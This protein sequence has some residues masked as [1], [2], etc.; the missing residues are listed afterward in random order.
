MKI[1]RKSGKSRK[2]R[3]PDEFPEKKFIISFLRRKPSILWRNMVKTAY[4]WR[5]EKNHLKKKKNQIYNFGAIA[6]EVKIELA[7]LFPSNRCKQK[8]AVHTALVVFFFLNCFFIWIINLHLWL[9][10]SK[11]L[12][13]RIGALIIIF[14]YFWIRARPYISTR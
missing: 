6:H 9:Y 4:I 5:F 1:W 8:W 10:L 13:N 11:Y 2:I 3:K 7:L 12:S 14:Y